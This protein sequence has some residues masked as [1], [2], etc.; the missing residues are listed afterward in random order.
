MLLGT[1]RKDISSERDAPPLDVR[2]SIGAVE[3]VVS[4]LGVSGVRVVEVITNEG[5]VMGFGVLQK[6]DLVNMTGKLLNKL[7]KRTIQEGGHQ[8]N[9][10]RMILS[11]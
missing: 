2:S 11:F 10:P 9:L 6:S 8:S 4:Q 5:N 7:L 3:R 1:V